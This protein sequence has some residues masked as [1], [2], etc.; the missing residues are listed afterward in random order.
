M[1]AQT[2]AVPATPAPI[3]SDGDGVSDD[4]DKCPG[5]DAG[6]V[7]GPDGCELDDDGD[8]VPN[9]K[10]KCPNTRQGV[11]VDR[12]GCEIIVRLK[13][14]LFEFDK[15]RLLP[16]AIA[17]L[18][19]AVS[20]LKEHDAK[21]IE[22]AGHTD[23][24]GT[25]EYNQALG[26]RRAIAVRDYLVKIGLKASRFVVKSYGESKPVATNETKEGRAQNRRVELID[27]TQ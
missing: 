2:A 4:H 17:I 3:D 24:I 14:P 5:T 18:D 20:V 26:E 11:K 6:I 12:N 8:G 19:Q 7:V 27:L 21:R 1:P 22:I 10:D 13:G 9:G 16:E 25:D 15:S 23:S